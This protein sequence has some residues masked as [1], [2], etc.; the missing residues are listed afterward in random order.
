MVRPALRTGTDQLFRNR[1]A[2]TPDSVVQDSFIVGIHPIDVCTMRDQKFNQC[3]T[4]LPD[5]V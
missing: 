2:A 1:L 3:F 4:G 5:S